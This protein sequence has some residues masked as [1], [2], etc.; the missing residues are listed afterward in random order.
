MKRVFYIVGPTG[1]GKS[2]LAARVTTE[3][4]GEIVS[5]DA[6]QL[7]AG[8]LL[9]TAQ[10][11]EELRGVVPH[12]LVG[13]FALHDEMNAEQFRRAALEAIDEI[14]AR[15]EPAF[16]VGGSGMYVKALTHG[17]SPL[18]SADPQL[19][20]QLNESGTA[21]LFSQL[22]TL[23]PK[24]AAT[25]DQHNRRRILRALEICLVAKRPA[26]DLRKRATPSREP[27]G[28]FLFRD[29]AE[30]SERINARVEMMFAHGVVDEVRSAGPLGP[31]AAKTLG[32][33]QIHDLIAGRISE[34]ECIASIQQATRRYAKRQLTWFQRQTNFEPLNLSLQGSPIE[35]ISRKARLSF[36][37]Q[38]D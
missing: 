33:S 15:G 2:E 34:A 11:N 20:A 12:H 3:L 6:F 19:R 23:D 32:V 4:G 28:V 36:A 13:K 1:V 37:Q 24:T 30:L 18:P 21:E 22:A 5:A 25:I 29:R 9:L 17:L 7:Y 16:V 27:A 14:N 31:T 35:W 8:L 26:S 38:D 10:P